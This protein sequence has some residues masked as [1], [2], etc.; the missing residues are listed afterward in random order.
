MSGLLAVLSLDGRPIDRAAIASCIDRLAARG[1]DGGGTWFSD[2]GGVCLSAA[3]RHVTRTDA[4]DRQPAARGDVTLITDS[5]LLARHELVDAL[6][7]AGQP[8]SVDAPDSDLLLSAWHAWGE[9]CTEHLSGEFSFVLW[10]ARQRVLFAAVDPLRV[11]ELVYAALP[12]V[13][14]IANELMSVLK[15]PAVSGE[16][17]EGTVGDFLLFGLVER[18]NKAATMF[19]DLRRLPPAHWLRADAASGAVSLHK[20]WDFP[21]DLPMRRL[22]KPDD[23]VAEF[24]A[25]FRQVMRERV[26]D[27]DRVMVMMSGGM[28]STSAAAMITDL[29]RSGDVSTRLS[30]HTLGYRRIIA[31][32]EPAFVEK[33]ARWLDDMPVHYM[34]GDDYAMTEPPPTRLDPVQDFSGRL[35]LD[36]E[37]T[38]AE[39]GTLG[40][41]GNGGDEIFTNTPFYKVLLQHSL[42]DAAQLYAWLWRM[43]GKRPHLG[44][45]QH[46]LRGLLRFGK[47][48]GNEQ[49]AYGYPGWLNPDFERRADLP[50]RWQTPWS[51][52]LKGSHRT[53]PEV[54]LY[55]GLGSWCE[56]TEFTFT[57][58]YTA[59]DFTEPFV[60]LRLVEFAMTLPPIPWNKRKLLLRQAMQGMLPPEVLARPKTPAPQVMMTLVSMPGVEWIDT[61][62]P[63]PEAE[64][65]IRRSAIPP[66]YGTHDTHRVGVDTRPLFFNEW[67]RGVRAE[68]GK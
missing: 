61:W 42:P 11:R 47:P 33:T 30:A 60:D 58:P 64:G 3:Q 37:R 34:Y 1:R 10:D 18:H 6:R 5:L 59:I 19:R 31:D 15:H 55:V 28:D 57:K 12:G 66:I 32:S 46:Y 9:R 52:T 29:I 20:Y 17:D 35:I 22:S 27:V 53:Q 26:Q 7:S 14:I 43:T 4:R 36:V 41:S 65:Y 62:Q 44:G 23:Y 68:L 25:L 63:F 39:M 56:R 40:V 51:Y 16:L 13:V 67:L 21:Y 2:D 8:A 50:A 54:P 38:M 49:P 45:V 24:R 48:E